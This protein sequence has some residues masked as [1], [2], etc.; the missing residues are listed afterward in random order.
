[1]LPFWGEIK[2]MDIHIR[3]RNKFLQQIGPSCKLKNI[4]RIKTR[5]KRAKE[6]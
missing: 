4:Y 3:S 1:M 6:G 5:T 2:M